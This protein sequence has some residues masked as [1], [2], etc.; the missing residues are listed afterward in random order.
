[1][2]D[3]PNRVI[4]A[5]LVF[6]M[7]VVG[8]LLY[9]YVR[10][11]MITQREVLNQMQQFLSTVSDS[12]QITQQDITNLNIGVN[13]SGGVYSVLVKRYT[14]TPLPTSAGNSRL[15][16]T[17]VDY[18]DSSGNPI[19]MNKGDLV[20]VIVTPIGVSPTQRLLSSIL[21]LEQDTRSVSLVEAVQ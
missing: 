19:T 9:V 11:D 10:Q 1:M 6:I 8:P 20:K 18:L 14:A 21:G 17:R 7:L 4:T 3:F 12:E 15:L 13:A 5:V 16:Y 2:F